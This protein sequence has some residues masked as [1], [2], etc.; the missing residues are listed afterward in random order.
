M[1]TIPRLLGMA[2]ALA[3]ASTASAFVQFTTTPYPDQGSRL[4]WK[5]RTVAYAVNMSAFTGQGCSSGD[6]AS[7]LAQ[8]SFPAW[9]EAQRQGAT[10]PCTDFKFVYAGETARTS[11]CS[12]R[13]RR[14]TPFASPGWPRESS[15]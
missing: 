7:Q 5:R 14:R 4:Q 12:S 15:C 11:S 13:G 2:C 10:A 6:A 3:F 8:A 9:A 1:K